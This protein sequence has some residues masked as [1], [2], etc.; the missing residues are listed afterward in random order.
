MRRSEGFGKDLVLKLLPGESLIIRGPCSLELENGSVECFGGL[1]TSPLKVGLRPLKQYYFY[2]RDEACEMTIRGVRMHRKIKG[3]PVP[4]SWRTLVTKVAGRL[5]NVALVIGPPSA[6]KSTLTTFLLNQLLTIAPSVYVID[7]DLG[8]N[9]IGPPGTVSIGLVRRPVIDLG[10]VKPLSTKFVGFLSPSLDPEKLNSAI[11][12]LLSSSRSVCDFLL[13]NSDG[14]VHG[15]GLVHKASLISR[16]NPDIVISLLDEDLNQELSSMVSFADIIRIE[17][18]YLSM[19]RTAIVRRAH[20]NMVFFRHLVGGRSV[21]YSLDD[22]PLLGSS[23]PKRGSLLGLLKDVELLGL[24][25]FEG[26][27]SGANKVKVFTK[28]KD[29]PNAIEVGQVDLEHLLPKLKPHET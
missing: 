11:I 10:R 19:S 24:G 16:A 22:A 5:P 18:S 27:E 9:D 7:A 12:A 25:V 29:V 14:W 4:R 8:Q 26:L 17:K 6:G 3:D 23:I 15:P 13:I 2:A 21:S 20:R 28:V 1:L